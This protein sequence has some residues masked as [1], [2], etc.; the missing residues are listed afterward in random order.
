[1]A[2]VSTAEQL[3]EAIKNQESTIE[4]EGDLANKTI[5]IRATG[6]IAWAV[7]FGAI[8][9]AVTATIL[10]FPT[11]GGTTV[12]LLAAPAATGI[13]GVPV[14]TAAIGIAVAAGGVG[15]LTQLRGYEEVKRADGLLV[16][17]RKQADSAP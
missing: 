8:V 3:G 7:A 13:L 2:K 5:R 6:N 9:V 10:A 11:G 16:L 15:A 1:M 17:R 12:G 14:T 4:I